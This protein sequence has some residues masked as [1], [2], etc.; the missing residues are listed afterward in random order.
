MVPNSRNLGPDMKK[1]NA[2]LFVLLFLSAVGID[3]PAYAY[4]DPGTGSMMIQ[5]ILGGVAGALVVG[6]LYWQRIK[7]FFR[8]KS[9]DDQ[10]KEPASHGD[11]E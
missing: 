11:A 10:S 5:L 8:G 9:I 4:L 7:A 3:S 6:N 1:S 2:F